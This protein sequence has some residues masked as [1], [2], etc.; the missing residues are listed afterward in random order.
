MLRGLVNFVR[1]FRPQHVLITRKLKAEC[2]VP[3]KCYEIEE[4]LN[5]KSQILDAEK[6]K[7]MSSVNDLYSWR[8]YWNKNEKEDFVNSFYNDNPFISSNVSF[9]QEDFEELKLLERNLLKFSG[10]EL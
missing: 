2:H 1:N 3:K 4:L 10:H 8:N 5:N 9:S 7:R 6:R